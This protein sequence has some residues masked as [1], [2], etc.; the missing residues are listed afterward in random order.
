MLAKIPCKYTL[1][2]CNA[3]FYDTDLIIDITND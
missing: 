1:Q 2:K 3:T